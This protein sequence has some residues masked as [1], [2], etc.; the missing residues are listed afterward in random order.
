MPLKPQNNLLSLSQR[1]LEEEPSQRRPQQTLH[2]RHPHEVR[3]R[4]T[5]KRTSCYVRKEGQ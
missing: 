3:L 2:G 4:E 5:R 1:V